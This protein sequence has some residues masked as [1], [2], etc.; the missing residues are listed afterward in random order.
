VEYFAKFQPVVVNIP[1]RTF[2]VETKWLVD[3]QR[4]AGRIL[5]DYG[6]DVNE[7]VEESLGVPLSPLA[8][9]AIDN[10]FIEALIASIVR[11]QKIHGNVIEGDG[12]R[13]R[14]SGA[15]VV[16][17]PGKS[18]IE[19]LF[20]VLIRG[21][22]LSNK[23]DIKIY[24]LHSGVSRKV[25]KAVFESVS[26]GKIKIVLSTNVAETSITIPDA[27]HIIDTG[28]VKESRYNA[29]T[30]LKELV[31][32]W[33][34][35]ASATQRSG[36]AGRTCPGVCYR[37]Y[38]QS[39]FE[40]H[41]P[42]QTTPEMVR[43][44]LD[45]LIL[46]VCLLYEQQR[47]PGSSVGVNPSLLLNQVPEPPSTTSLEKACQH[48]MDVGALVPV[49]D[50]NFRLTPL[51]FH[52]SRLPMDPKVGKVLIVGCLLGCAENALTVAAALSCPKSCFYHRFGGI[53]DRQYE[54]S[55]DRRAQIIEQGFGG[56]DWRG[57]TVKGDFMA[58]IACYRAWQE[59]PTDQD[60][61]LFARDH[62]LDHNV[63][64]DIKELR[65]SFGDM[66][67]E[68]GFCGEG[69]GEPPNHHGEDAL[70]TSA[71]WVAG[72]YPNI[73]TLIRPRKGGPKGGR[74][75][76]KEGDICRPQLQS[77]Q[78]SR[79]QRAAETG[80]DAYAVY[81]TKHRSVTSM[82]QSKNGEVFLSNVNFVSRYALLLFSGALHVE[83]NAVIV[84][85][86]LKFKIGETGK[87]GA[88]LMLAI[89]RELDAMLLTQIAGGAETRT[90]TKELLAVVRQL[91]ADE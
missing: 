11:Q 15:I 71:C 68:A 40:H 54:E 74:L 80:K 72:L 42:K 53:I 58:V 13:V 87:A 45:E 67:Q 35:Q 14:T 66:L 51:G 12:S 37:L 4:L 75:L 69:Y 41:F 55:V 22:N 10:H 76:T 31:T 57:G 59:C 24:K 30:R 88:V 63:M 65:R 60:R 90:E 82:S 21:A 23:E 84:D 29:G 48:L 52:L 7:Q 26:S 1:G 44:P 36:R 6:D 16:F 5:Q 20:R 50:E 79:V 81:H 70:L 25:Q 73:C 34:S 56:K 9:I 28:R 89:R 83:K 62:A 32:V 49:A 38:S 61:A 47:K 86:W 17:L 18:E 46:Q 8:S 2:P 39:F 43:T 77:F 3:C 91:L 19:A 33:T 78:R 27:S 64:N 85:G